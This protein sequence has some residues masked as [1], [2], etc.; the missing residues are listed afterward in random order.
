MPLI[1]LCLITACKKKDEVTTDNEKNNTGTVVKS[2]KSILTSSLWQLNKLTWDNTVRPISSKTKEEYTE[3][4]SGGNFSKKN[5]SDDIVFHSGTW[6]FIDNETKL[7]R[8]TLDKNDVEQS[9]TTLITSLLDTSWSEQY[10]YNTK[11]SGVVTVE[12]TYS[13]FT[14]GL[15]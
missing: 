4:K 3:F 10:T 11:E 9:D 1:A 12:E 5:K 13:V 8:T 14:Q 15:K 6:K 7:V 2:K